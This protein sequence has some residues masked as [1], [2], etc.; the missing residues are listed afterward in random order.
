MYGCWES[1]MGELQVSHQWQSKA[2]LA[3][4]TRAW[5]GIAYTWVITQS[6]SLSHLHISTPSLIAPS[7]LFVF[8]NIHGHASSVISEY[9]TG[10]LKAEGNHPAMKFWSCTNVKTVIYKARSTSFLPLVESVSF[11]SCVLSKTLTA[12]R[13]RDTNC[14]AFLAVYHVHLPPIVLNQQVAQLLLYELKLM[15][16]SFDSWFVK[17]THKH[18]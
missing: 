9:L 14:K 18:N 17:H 11:P 4:T 6:H 13:Q 16:K 1:F 5:G 2:C 12:N 7:A 8:S 15:C 3:L 10:K